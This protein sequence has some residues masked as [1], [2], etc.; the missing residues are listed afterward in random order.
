M[1]YRKSLERWF[2]NIRAAQLLKHR[3]DRDRGQ[4]KDEGNR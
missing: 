2:R 3:S 4:G 1:I